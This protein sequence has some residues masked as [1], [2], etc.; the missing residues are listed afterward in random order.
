MTSFM[1]WQFMR[2]LQPSCYYFQTPTA[3]I[4]PR[5]RPKSCS[6]LSYHFPKEMELFQSC[7]Q[8]CNCPDLQS[9]SLSDLSSEFQFFSSAA[10]AGAAAAM[11]GSFPVTRWKYLT[12]DLCLSFIL[13]N[14][15]IQG[16][17]ISPYGLGQLH[18]S[19]EEKKS[20]IC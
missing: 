18:S 15:H 5:L 16:H 6:L 3:K 14:T 10:A 8:P 17:C 12:P 9:R 11:W 4:S 7:R 2:P 13:L 19:S 20:G 1:A